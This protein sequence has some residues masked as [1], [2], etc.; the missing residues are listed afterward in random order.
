MLAAT[1]LAKRLED[2]CCKKGLHYAP[3]SEKHG[4]KSS[5]CPPETT[6]KHTSVYIHFRILPIFLFFHLPI[7]W[8]FLLIRSEDSNSHETHSFV[9]ISCHGNW[10]CR[11]FL[12][13]LRRLR[14]SKRLGSRQSFHKSPLKMDGWNTSFCLGPGLFLEANFTFRECSYK[15]YPSR[16][17]TVCPWKV[18]ETQ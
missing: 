11:L 12:V 13:A 16:S 3:G 8:S 15:K 6:G 4:W 7:L 10:Q 14:H 1:L 17:L 2:P 5:N 18:T 9:L